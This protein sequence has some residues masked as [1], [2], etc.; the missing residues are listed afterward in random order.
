M[1]MLAFGMEWGWWVVPVAASV[2]A[3]LFLWHAKTR[4]FRRSV[5]GEFLTVE[6]IRDMLNRGERLSIVDVR[7]ESAYAASATTAHGAVRL[8]PA[9]PV[10]DAR[11]LEIP[12]GA[13]I[14]AFCS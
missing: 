12:L 5:P 9:H 8:N 10:D 6:E 2:G 11:R 14:A 3:G 13:R 7:S 1:L 4:E